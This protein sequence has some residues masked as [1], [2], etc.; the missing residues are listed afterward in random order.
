MPL[1]EFTLQETI[2]DGYDEPIVF[3]EWTAFYDGLVYD[4]FSHVVPS[5]GGLVEG[6]ITIPNTNYACDFYNI[7]TSVGV[8]G[9]DSVVA[10]P[11]DESNTLVAHK[12]FCPEGTAADAHLL[13]YFE[14][15]QLADTPVE[16]TLT[17]DD[18]VAVQETVDGT[19]HVGRRAARPVHAQGNDPGR[20]RGAGRLV[21]LDRLLRRGRVRRL[22]AAE[23]VAGR[24]GDGEI[25]I[26]N[27]HYRCDFINAPVAI[28]DL[29]A[30]PTEVPRESMT[31]PR[32]LALPASRS[33]SPNAVRRHPGDDIYSEDVEFFS[34]W[35]DLFTTEFEFT[36][37]GDGG[38]ANAITSGFGVTFADV[39][40]GAITISET[41]PP[42]W[43]EPMALCWSDQVDPAGWHI[44]NDVPW[45]VAAG[46]R[47]SACG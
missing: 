1:G 45:N 42:G 14:Q 47:S 7:A 27:T 40:E 16:F 39:P 2:P 25:S 4:D 37:S 22:L 33:A 17:N 8:G 18:G 20:V 28:D 13:D 32:I 11:Q 35:C 9:P 6:E 21:R 3:C 15:C 26:P 36:V 19:A 24:A 34:E 23:G 43:I 38:F 29:Q 12:W 44:G 5:A 41:L 46:E 10:N 31:S 30:N